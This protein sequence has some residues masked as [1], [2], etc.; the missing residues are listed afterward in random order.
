VPQPL[1]AIPK[2]PEVAAPAGLGANEFPLDQVVVH[3]IDVGQG[4]AELLEFSCAAVL[5]DTGGETTQEV[6]GRQNLVEFL[7]AFF[8]RTHDGTILVQP[9]TSRRAYLCSKAAGVSHSE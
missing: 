1:K 4:D 9:E 6:D 8:K 3:F 2:A 7:D 5:V